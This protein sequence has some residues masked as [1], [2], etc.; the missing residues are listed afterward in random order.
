MSVP[1][2]NRRIKLCEILTALS[3]PL[4]LGIYPA[5]YYYT[6]NAELV[7]LSSLARVLAMYLV[8]ILVLFVLFLFIHRFKAVRAANATSIFL[9]FFNTYGII[10]TLLMQADLFRVEHLTLLPLF[11]FLAGYAIWLLA[12]IKKRQA[13][14][15][16]RWSG[17]IFV[18]LFIIFIIRLIPMEVKKMQ[19][20]RESVAQMS[21]GK[22]SA[23]SAEQPDIYYLLFD[24][25]AGFRSMREY[26]GNQE[27]DQFKAFLEDNGFF[28]AEHAMAS[29]DHTV[30]QMA[31]RMNYEPYVYD[32]SQKS[33]WF[34]TLADSRGLSLLESLG[35]TT[36]VFEEIS[37]LYPWLPDIQA[38]YLFQYDYQSGKDSS[39]I[40]DDY[41]IMIADSSML[42]VLDKYY[43]FSDPTKNHHRNFI[44]F[45]QQQL[46]D[47]TAYSAPRFVYVHLMLPHSSFLFDKNGKMVDPNFYGDWNYYEGQYMYTI[48]YAQ[49][50]ITDILEKADPEKP[51]IIILQSDHGARIRANNPQLHDFPPEYMRD[52]LYALYLPGYDI[53]TLPQDINPINTLPIVFNYYLGENIPLQ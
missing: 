25:F 23:E 10:H 42:K 40:F 27:V 6:N 39:F 51:P 9:L 49:T 19:P 17:I 29:S 24:E 35:Y 20:H 18:T 53:S 31:T 15:L 52:I 41:S 37:M 34:E 32:L 4:V 28:V 38:D 2:R 43:K 14:V 11:F 7:R 22:I 3:V 8:L 46:P 30:H 47:L 36:L 1:K 48:K 45:V 13:Q 44:E 5:I 26:W 21:T 50:L 16:W 33:M 12:R